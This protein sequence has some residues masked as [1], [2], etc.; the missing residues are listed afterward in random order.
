[1][2]D[3]E[4]ALRARF[5]LSGTEL[6]NQHLLNMGTQGTKAVQK[7]KQLIRY[8]PLKVMA[9]SGIGI[10]AEPRT[11]ETA[12]EKSRAETEGCGN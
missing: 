5:E 12:V 10:K 4:T 6:L 7:W 2:H 1:M 8:L 11:S 3:T 9:K